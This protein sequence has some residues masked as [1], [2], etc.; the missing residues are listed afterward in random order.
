MIL[1]VLESTRRS[2]SPAQHTSEKR[3]QTEILTIPKLNPFT[4]HL[5]FICVFPHQ[6]ISSKQ[7]KGT[8]KTDTT[9]SPSPKPPPSP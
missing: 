4:Q 9:S 2:Q 1:C 5:V 3:Q 7:M 8:K 6:R